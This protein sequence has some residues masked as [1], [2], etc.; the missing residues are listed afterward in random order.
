MNL[1]YINQAILVGLGLQM[2]SFDEI[3][4]DIKDLEVRN[5]LPLFQKTMIKFTKLIQRCYEKEVLQR[6]PDQVTTQVNKAVSN[7]SKA[8][9]Q[10]AEQEKEKIFEHKGQKERSR[11]NYNLED[12]DLPAGEVAEG[13]VVTIKRK[14]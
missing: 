5:A 9:K 4:K 1:G 13:E 12:G 11:V 10:F 2:K 6:M 3:C 8:T 14:L 7:D